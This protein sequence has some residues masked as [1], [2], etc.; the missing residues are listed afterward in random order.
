MCA[1]VL[2]NVWVQYCGG[3]K[4][5]MA[6]FKQRKKWILCVGGEQNQRLT[7]T[8][9]SWEFEHRKIVHVG[10]FSDWK[11]R[12]LNL[13]SPNHDLC[14]VVVKRIMS[15]PEEETH[16][17]AGWSRCNHWI[18]SLWSTLF[19]DALLRVIR[20]MK[21]S[22]RIKLEGRSVDKPTCHLHRVQLQ[23]DHNFFPTFFSPV[24][25]FVSLHPG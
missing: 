3:K 4:I 2:L 7:K 18:K 24:A 8:D 20:R 15:K 13:S 10:I 1:S 12:N 14:M 16:T 23:Q 25:C 21:R 5:G 22:S 17:R 6:I 11:H 19:I 9:G